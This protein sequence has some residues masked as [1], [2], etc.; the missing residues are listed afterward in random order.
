MANLCLIFKT[1]K[2]LQLT[3]N[4]FHK[5]VVSI[6]LAET[7]V[8]RAQTVTTRTAGIPTRPGSLYPTL[9]ARTQC[10]K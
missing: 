5:S 10:Y 6:S 2:V 4:V 3:S 8:L 9:V 7:T 1:Y